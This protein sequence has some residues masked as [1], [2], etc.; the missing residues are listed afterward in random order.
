MADPVYD[1]ASLLLDCL[2]EQF[3]VPNPNLATP[4]LFSLQAGEQIS[5]DIDPIIGEDLCCTGFGWVR[6]GDAYPSS[7]FPTA[8]SVTNK[9]F[10]VAWAQEFEV[11]L[12]GCWVPGSE[13]M[14]ATPAQRAKAALEDAE[15]L[16][17]LKLTACCYGNNTQVRQRGRLWTIT[18]ISV[19]GPRGNCISRVMNLLI[20][21]PK[22]C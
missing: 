9:C 19:S 15:R 4:G 6:I 20:Q 11:G 8:D 12:L 5:E 17:M 13:P 2:Q 3:A 7:N 1:T 18:G 10:P 16:R 22:C 21:L 14:M